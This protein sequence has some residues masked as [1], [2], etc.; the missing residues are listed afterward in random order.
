MF[1]SSYSGIALV[2][3]LSGIGGGMLLYALN[4][5]IAMSD[6]AIREYSIVN[7]VAALAPV[8]LPL[9]MPG[10][11]AKY[12]AAGPYGIFV[13]YSLIFSVLLFTMPSIWPRKGY[14]LAGTGGL[15]PMEFGALMLTVLLP[16]LAGIALFA[17]QDFIGQKLGWSPSQMGT[18]IT[19]SYLF[20]LIGTGAAGWIDDRFGWFQPTAIAIAGLCASVLV[21]TATRSASLFVVATFAFEVF[22]F[23]VQPYLLAGCARVDASGKVAA[24]G[25]GILFFGIALGP[26]VGGYLVQNYG[27]RSIG[28]FMVVCAVLAVL[29]SLQVRREVDTSRAPVTR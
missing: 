8:P 15:R 10:L 18:V 11:L 17:F 16:V 19:V 20:S 13:V 28:M 23:A 27:V 12:G 25:A 29:L 2:L 9:F 5:A 4:A 22:Y 14:G 1:A 7:A 3:A 24:T 26:S 6:H 21:S